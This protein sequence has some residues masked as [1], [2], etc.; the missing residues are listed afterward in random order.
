[1][2][3][4][5]FNFFFLIITLSL[6]TFQC[7]T[8]PTN[9]SGEYP[10]AVRNIIDN[11]CATAGCHNS[12]S[13][14]NAGGLRLDRW[15]HLFNGTASGSVIIPFNTSNSS[16]LFFVND[17]PDL[18]PT[19]QPRMPVNMPPLS[20]SEYKILKDWVERGAPDKVGNVMYATN[21]TT[22][23]KIYITQQGCDL[24]AVVDGSTNMIMRYIP[25]GMTPGIE[26]PHCVRFDHEGKYAYVTFTSGEYL[27]RIDASTDAVV[28]S[29]KLG[30]GSW[31]LFHLSPDGKKMLVSDYGSGKIALID[32]EAFQIQQMYYD[33]DNP[34]GIASNASFDTFYITGQFGN[35]IYRLLMNGNVRKYSLDDNEPNILNSGL[36]PHEIITSPDYSKYFVSC[37]NSNEVRV[38]DRKT[39]TLL[40]TI[41]VGNMPQEFSISKKQPYIFVSCEEDI[42]PDYFG[43]KGSI[44]VINYNTLEIVKRI[45]GPFYQV[46]GLTVDD[47]N[48]Q[49]IVASRNIATSGPAPH[50]TS[51]C[52][53]R[54]GYYSIIDIEKLELKSTRRFEASVD[55]YSADTRFK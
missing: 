54:N 35:T 29:L 9:Y 26:V 10:D 12:I 32:L 51:E 37:Q 3:G 25:I 2:K 49:L 42:L 47:Q 20:T 4:N 19:L 31:N 39:N 5:R 50:H 40:K 1:M 27:Q 8:P 52:G 15:E 38:M 41:P 43:F 16:L 53:G 33:F 45:G 11:K 22:R 17:D 30:V 18:G 21:P 55:P 24:I 6:F 14:P 36:N 46:H 48:N 44:Y 28:G 7:V 34:H 23:Q 13:F